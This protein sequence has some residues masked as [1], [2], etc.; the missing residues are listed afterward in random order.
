M[1]RR[2]LSHLCISTFAL[3]VA[4]PACNAIFGISGGEPGEATSSTSGS[5]STVATGGGGTGTTSGTSSTTGSGSTTSS[6]TGTGGSVP[7]GGGG[8]KLSKALF[9]KQ[10]ASGNAERG[11]AVAYTNTGELFW[12][13]SYSGSDM[14]LGP[15]TLPYPQPDGSYEGFDIFLARY[16]MAGLHKWSVGYGGALDQVPYAMVADPNADVVMTGSMEGSIDFGGT[17]LTATA[18]DGFVVKLGGNNGSVLWARAI[19]GPGDELGEAIAVDGDGDVVVA[20]V[21]NGTVDVGCG[22]KDQPAGAGIFLAKLDKADGHCIWSNKYKADTRFY[23][24]DSQGYRVSVTVDTQNDDIY[25][26]GGAAGPNFGQGATSSFGDKDVFVFKASG[27]GDYKDARI[28]GAT[29][30]DG[31]QYATGIALDDCGNVLLAGAF[32]HS[33]QIGGTTLSAKKIVA[34][35]ADREDIF[36]AKLDSSLAPIWAKAFGDV[37]YQAAVGVGVDMAGN[38]LVSGNLI[39][40]VTSTGVDFGGGALLG[41][42]DYTGSPGVYADDVFALQLDGAGNYLWARRWGTRSYDAPRAMAAA[43]SGRMALTGGFITD[44]MPSV[45]DF[46]GTS[47]PIKASYID[48]FLAVVGP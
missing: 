7:C 5:S 9:V 17:M 18:L 8:T 44:S 11:T 15:S 19:S 46:G 16:D 1:I 14:A 33:L 38:V 22:P 45:L 20:G 2:H 36:V 47:L 40:E 37:G 10:T 31:T 43:R 30:D 39:D 12:A 25:L 28:F 32:T 41:L 29:I 26:A 6:S 34:T 27:N 13:G 24:K 35:D 3:L 48:G 4:L 42:G 21:T 23:D